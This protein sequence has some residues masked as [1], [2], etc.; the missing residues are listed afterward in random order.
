[1]HTT[2]IDVQGEVRQEA[3]KLSPGHL[4]LL[5]LLD[6]P[7]ARG[8][9]HR[10]MGGAVRDHRQQ[11]IRR[12]QGTLQTSEEYRRHLLAPAQHRGVLT[13]AEPMP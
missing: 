3:R 13:L 1:M 6:N 11:P 7:K 2:P 12:D 4:P 9:S 8:P 10:A 5:P